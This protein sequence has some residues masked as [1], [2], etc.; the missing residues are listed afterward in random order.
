MLGQTLEGRQKIV[1]NEFNLLLR[2]E[3]RDDID[4]IVRCFICVLA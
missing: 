1:L 3:T 4:N 2:G